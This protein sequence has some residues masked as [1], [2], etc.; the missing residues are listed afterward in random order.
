MKTILS[1]RDLHM[2]R[3]QRELLFVDQLDI[4]EGEIL[5]VIGP[6]GAG[7]STLLLALARL[8]APSQGRIEF[9]G[10]PWE[11]I[12]PLD[13][14]RRI[15]L[16]LQEPLLLKTTVAENIASGLKFRGTDRKVVRQ[17]TD[18]W[19]ERLGIAHLRNR[20]AHRLSGG[21][22]QRV[23]LARALAI[24]PDLLFLDEPF[25]AL[26]APTRSR[27]IMDFKTLLDETQITTLFVTHD[28]DEAKL[29]GSRV[30]VIMSG[31]LK[32]VG[33]PEE[34]FS[35]PVDEEVAN[36]VGVETIL[37]G[38]VIENQQGRVICETAVGN[39]EAVGDLAP[40]QSVRICLR[41]EDITLTIENGRKPTSARNH[42]HGVI[43]QIIPYGP[44]TRVLVDCGVSVMVL[45][46]RAS[47]EEMQ[48][49]PGLEVALAFKASAVHL[50]RR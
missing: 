7:K 21:E 18:E 27:L 13:Y 12:S 33:Q 25:S 36:F 47:A 45:V 11:Q 4:Y 41:P 2:R 24:Q 42:L 1:V 32:Q 22:A 29:F 28:Q 5:T 44:L 14:R 10:Q 43:R 40:G 30:A 34:I 23:S 3:D 35:A 9:M 20:Q 17:R 15:A 38:K 8:M 48:L 31:I 49:T 19:L 37:P 39:V 6:N 16:V 50:I 46:T 26:D